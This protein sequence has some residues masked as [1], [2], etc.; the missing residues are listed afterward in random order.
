MKKKIYSIVAAGFLFIF[1]AG[2]GFAQE[3]ENDLK[4]EIDLLANNLTPLPGVF[5]PSADLSGRGF[6]R[7]SVWPQSVSAPEVLA[8]WQ[9]DV[10]FGGFLRIQYNLWGVYQFAKDKV[11]QADHLAHYES[12]IK[13]VNDSGGTA[14]LDIFGTPAGFGRIL[15]KVSMPKD[16]RV[17]K[18]VVKGL[19][20]DLSCVK[21]YNIWYEVWSAPDIDDFFLGNA[22]D[23]FNLYRAAAEAVKELEAEYKINIPIGGPSV[24]AWFRGVDDNTIATPERGLI[25]G[26]IRFCKDYKLPLDFIS[27]HSYT[28][29]PQADL[30]NTVYKK[31]VPTLIRDWLSYFHFDRN[32]PLLVDEWGFDRNDNRSAERDGSSYIA[33]SFIPARLRYM[34]ESG[35][36]GQAYFSLEDFKHNKEGVF[37]NTGIFTYD[38]ERSA[39]KG[40]PKAAYNVFRML[41]ML[42]SDFFAAGLND[43][44]SGVIATRSKEE[45]AILIYNYVDPDIAMN[46]ISRNIASL[47]SGERSAV[48]NF[49]R[50][51]KLNK[52]LSGQLDIARSGLGQ[53]PKAILKKAKELD[54]QAAKLKESP[55]TLRIAFKNLKGDFFYQRYSMEPPCAYD[56]D[57]LA[58][59]DKV[60]LEAPAHEEILQLK[61]YSVNLIILKAKPGEPVEK[62]VAVDVAL[63]QA[64]QNSAD[65]EEKR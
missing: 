32:L 5:R 8:A 24:S 44:F 15:D 3:R 17:F 58:A 21:K 40:K 35:I 25:Y 4:L 7:D 60:I 22:Q 29:D 39:Y 34:R 16:L 1:A 14:I 57:F 50:S 49:V 11:V 28:S 59:D 43:D 33:A 13:N 38:S 52:F 45:I 41:G 65:A 56:C 36:D 55:R 61:P 63:E 47:G 48:A 23:Y 19:I 2:T 31:N 30:E 26:L 20:R 54:A 27:W 18:R 9:K 51:H 12:I 10:G 37:R 53:R 64:K 6:H 62:V 46:Y 42:K